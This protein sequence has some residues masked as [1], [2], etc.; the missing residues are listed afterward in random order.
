VTAPVPA[1]RV[2]RLNDRPPAVEGDY[3]LYW[4]IAARRPA[5]NFALDRAVE[6]GRR[7]GRPVLVFEPLRAGYPWASDRL[8]A[9]VLQGMAA[10]RDALAGGPFGYYPY[11]EPEPGA[12]RGLLAA[13]AARAV[14][15]VTDDFPAFFLPRMTA[16]AATRLP[17]LVEAVDGNGLLPLAAAD[18]VFTTAY[19]FRRSLQAA[20]PA[21]LAATPAADPAAAAGLPAF[22]GLPTATARDWP[23]AGDVLLSATAS[24]LAAL[25]IDH[26]VAPVET[27]GGHVAARAALSAFLRDRL[28]RYADERSQPE[29]DAASGLSP[30]LHFG[31]LSVHEV[32]AGLMTQEGWTSR[33]LPASGAGQRAGWWGASPPAEAF[34]D[35]LV[36]WREVGFNMCHREPRYAQYDS[37]P[38]WARATLD[39]HA[40]DRRE[41]VYPLADF[42][43]AATHDP[44][45]NAAQRQLLREGRMHNY[46]RML[47]GKKILEWTASPSDALAVM[48]ELN[49]KYAL[50]GRD[51][52]SYT[53]IFWV[54]GRYDRPWAPERPVFGTIRYMSSENT[55]RKLR[56]KGYLARYGPLA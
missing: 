41:H 54:L 40:G 15:V 3:V 38:A 28:P 10:T 37:L 1:L 22:T 56:V 24:S 39:R 16:A 50:D 29:S 31:H 47:W 9:F 51:P 46:L 21:H 8:H 53:G 14:A 20:L 17:I 32:F 12:G 49:N 34:L 7:T 23:P 48:I 35:E 45:W 18:R 19:S 43:R 30:W 25:P 26:A 44:L 6:W 36:T 11:V 13:L 27:R 42:E 2:R 55:A 33:R 4:M 5:W 52:N